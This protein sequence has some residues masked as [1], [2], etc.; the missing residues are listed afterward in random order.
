MKKTTSRR[1]KLAGLTGM[2]TVCLLLT[3][4]VVPP[5]D[6]DTSGDYVVTQGDLPFQS[7]RPG[8]TN[9]PYTPPT[10]SPTPAPTP[11]PAPMATPAPTAAPTIDPGAL[12]HE[13]E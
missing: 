5:E 1:W 11:T 2:L 10:A 12:T 4:C 7:L 13:N 9:T 6:I 3:G 8:P